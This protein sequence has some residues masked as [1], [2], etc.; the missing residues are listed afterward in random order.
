MERQIDRPQPKWVRFFNKCRY[1]QGRKLTPVQFHDHGKGLQ[2]HY[3]LDKGVMH[4]VILVNLYGM[5]LM[6]FYSGGTSREGGNGVSRVWS[7]QPGRMGWSHSIMFLVGLAMVP[8]FTEANIVPNT[9][10]PRIVV[11]GYDSARPERVRSSAVPQHCIN[12]G[13]SMETKTMHEG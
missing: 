5:E 10:P 9:S 6:N 7:W 3:S 11:K 2:G 8:T 12:W 13:S 1:E 4:N